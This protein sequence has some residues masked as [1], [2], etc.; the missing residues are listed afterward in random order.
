MLPIAHHDLRRLNDDLADLPEGQRLLAALDVHDA[1]VHIGQGHADRAFLVLAVHRTA[2]GRE[3]RLGHG[4]SFQQPAAG[5]R[6]EAMLGLGHQRRRRR[7]ADLHGLEVHLAR[8]DGRVIEQG[9]E[10]G[11]HAVQ[12]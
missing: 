1:H 2:H 9:D 7:P 4:V 3:H 5:Q 12:A 8:L 6:F 10:Q 11:R